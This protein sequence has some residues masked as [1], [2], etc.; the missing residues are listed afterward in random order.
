MRGSQIYKIT[1]WTGVRSLKIQRF[2]QVSSP[3]SDAGKSPEDIYQ[4][5]K[6]INWTNRR[7][8]CGIKMEVI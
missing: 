4:L 7:M 2:P 8:L 6:N 1:N 5:D 3:E